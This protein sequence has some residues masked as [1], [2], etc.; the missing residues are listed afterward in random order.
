MARKGKFG[1]R[2][3]TEEAPK[4]DNTKA[5]GASKDKPREIVAGASIDKAR[6]GAAAKK[7][8]RQNEVA[9]KG[10][11]QTNVNL[12]GFIFMCNGATKADCF[13]YRVFGLNEGKKNLVEQV[14]KGMRLF[15]FDIDLRLLYGI[16]SAAS[17]GSFKLE[18]DAFGGAFP[19]QVRFSI[20]KDCLPLPE[21]NFRAA[22][23]DNYLDK[24]KFKVE[25][26]VEQVHRLVKLFRPLPGAPGR[27]PPRPRMATSNHSDAA[28]RAR[29][30]EVDERVQDRARFPP[31]T[32]YESKYAPSDRYV[33]DKQTPGYAQSLTKYVQVYPSDERRVS[34]GHPQGIAPRAVRGSD[35][36]YLGRELRLQQELTQHSQ[37]G[38]GARIPGVSLSLSSHGADPLRPLSDL[39][40]PR[41]RD[42]LYSGYPQVDVDSLY[43]QRQHIPDVRGDLLDRRVSGLDP[44]VESSLAY[45]SGLSSDL[46]RGRPLN[47]IYASAGYGGLYRYESSTGLLSG[48][49]TGSSGLSYGGELLPPSRY[50]GGGGGGGY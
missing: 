41:A 7:G 4:R 19:W 37:A 38:L 10:A 2:Q 32:K 45:T 43:R 16:Y 44:L 50:Y 39:R 11:G 15:L 36:L 26:T 5:K 35:D 27:S 48:G 31:R 17:H 40:L 13:K 30:L 8:A 12:G 28:P 3:N 6:E 24:R 33:A 34:D 9:K 21:D 20:Q 1:K 18:R 25:L 49:V 22:I 23:K 47:D 42:E 46:L 29:F 14:R